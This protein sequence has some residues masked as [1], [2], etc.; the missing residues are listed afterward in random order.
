MKKTLIILLFF[1]VGNIA[2][3][4]QYVPVDGPLSYGWGGIYDANGHRLSR[5]EGK[6]GYFL[7]PDQ[8]RRFKRGQNQYFWGVGLFVTGFAANAFSVGLMEGGSGTG[9]D[10]VDG[11]IIAFAYCYGIPS[12]IGG[13]TLFF[14]GRHKLKDLT[15]DYN[16]EHQKN[17]ASLSWGPQKHGYGLAL[18]F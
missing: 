8:Q 9:N 13:V 5:S 10:G 18:T 2:A 1:F 17:A 16:Y 15:Q 6:S 4:A 3:H 7:T 12:M 11:A 14:C